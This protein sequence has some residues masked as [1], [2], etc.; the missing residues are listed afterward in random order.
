MQPTETSAI[1][2]IEWDTRR[3]SAGANTQKE[4]LLGGLREPELLSNLHVATLN[5]LRRACILNALPLCRL[6]NSD[7]MMT[8]DGK[9]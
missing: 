8:M 3:S 9:Q 5:Q 7:V 2:V 1:I 6:L 4:H